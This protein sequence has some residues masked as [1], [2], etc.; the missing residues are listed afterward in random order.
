MVKR[1]SWMQADSVAAEAAKVRAALKNADKTTK[2]TAKTSKGSVAINEQ[3]LRV[4]HS[5]G[6]DPVRTTE[7]RIFD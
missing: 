7:V 4:M 1:H 3:I 5:L 6:I 2:T